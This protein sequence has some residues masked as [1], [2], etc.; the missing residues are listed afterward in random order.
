MDQ[1]DIELMKGI[2]R[3]EEA[4]FETFKRRHEGTL[5]LHL[6][7][8]VGPGDVD[9]LMQEVL[10]RLW[11]RAG[12]WDGS[13]SPLAWLL[14]IATNLALNHIR[15]TRSKNLTSLVTDQEDEMGDPT[16]AFETATASADEAARMRDEASRLL[17]LMGQMP[18]DKRTVLHMARLEQTKLQDIAYQLGVPL[19]T[20]KSR[21]H[22]ATQW[23]AE[24]WE[25]EE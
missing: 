16:P 11:D 4:V 15:D 3:R 6:R 24:R 8:Y 21:L 18:E 2:Q 23:L 19:G 12:Q 22:S 1:S 17:D 5:R 14:R 7:R 10:L 13:G 9:D 25:E 20:I